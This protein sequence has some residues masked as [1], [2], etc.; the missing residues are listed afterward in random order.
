MKILPIFLAKIV[1]YLNFRKTDSLAMVEWNSD[2]LQKIGI[3]CTWI[4]YVVPF[5][6]MPLSNRSIMQLAKGML[7]KSKQDG[8]EFYLDLSGY[9]NISSLNKKYFKKTADLNFITQFMHSL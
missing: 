8:S 4:P 3:L 6:V 2:N 5:H 7:E 9:R 1:I